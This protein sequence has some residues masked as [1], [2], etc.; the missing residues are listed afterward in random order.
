MCVK[1]GGNTFIRSKCGIEWTRNGKVYPK[2]GY[3]PFEV[4]SSRCMVTDN[5]NTSSCYSQVAQLPNNTPLQSSR[6]LITTRPEQAENYISPQTPQHVDWLAHLLRV[7]EV[8]GLNLGWNFGCHKGGFCS[9]PAC[10][11]RIRSGRRGG[12]N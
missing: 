1:G 9:I 10:R 4:F 3:I 6:H 11:R 5:Y 2:C 8:P 7:R 12:F